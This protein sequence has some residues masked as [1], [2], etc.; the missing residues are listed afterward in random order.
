MS[1]LPEKF[2]DKN[3]KGAQ[4]WVKDFINGEVLDVVHKEVTTKNEDGT[5]TTETVATSKTSVNMDRLFALAETNN[6]NV[7]KY[8]ADVEKKNAPGRLRM[9]IGNMLRAA[10]RKRHGLYSIAGEWNDAPAEFIGDTEVKEDRQGNK[11]AKV[12]PEEETEAA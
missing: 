7:D 5:E 12:K 4:D 10:A 3:Y 2:R 1:I 11:I 8:K 9:T 6:L